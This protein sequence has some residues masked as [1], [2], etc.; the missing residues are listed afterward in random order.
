MF[1]L[2]RQRNFALAC[3]AALLS[4]TGD[5]LLIAGL[6][7][8]VFQITGSGFVT[9][10]VF[11]VE[12]APVLLFGSLAGVV[13]DRWD[14]R[15]AML[16]LSIVQAAAL[17]PLFAVRSAHELWLV[18]TVAAG[19]AF[20]AMLVEPTK[21]A[22]LPALV[23]DD[24]LVS[25]NGLV[26]LNVNLGR[27]IG[28]PLGGLLAATGSVAG[29]A[30]GDAV[31]FL[32]V[33]VLVAGLRIAA[34]ARHRSPDGAAA[35]RV[36]LRRSWLEGLRVIGGDR[37]VAVALL[38]AATTAVAQGLFVVL[39]VVFVGR[40][41]HGGGAEIGLLRGVQAVGSIVGGLIVGAVGRRLVPTTLLASSA[42]LFGLFSLAAWNAPI[43]T[44]AEG[45]YL[46]LF[47]VIGI[48][49]IAHLSAL[50]SLLQHRIPASVLGRVFS[51]LYTVYN[52]FQA[53][54]M[55]AAG[56]L[57]DTLGV[58]RVLDAQA[59][60]Y[61]LAGAVALIG[62][63]LRM[64]HATLGVHEGGSLSSAGPRREDAKATGRR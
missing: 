2:L 11:M 19:E 35:A 61:L 42:L 36:G 30:I 59:S 6:P 17:L 54:G 44:T 5:W 27:L 60:L 47:A 7:I 29:I 55:L 32:V 23:A 22:L 3:L 20:L 10:T 4:E 15:R 26:A 21:N 1:A 50:T 12:L 56:V 63:R 25:A 49:G 53:L 62:P 13:V 34:T 37:Q 58:T 43:V 8:Y 28:S 9:S 46:G 16:V 45:F 24:Q 41:L 14:K 40:V 51:T 33:A 39:F 48:P 57:G 64:R 38:V 52:G 31:S 18:Y